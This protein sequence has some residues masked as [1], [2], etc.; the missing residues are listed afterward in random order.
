M[1]E[2]YRA[3]NGLEA[4]LVLSSIGWPGSH[5]AREECRSEDHQLCPEPVGRFVGSMNFFDFLTNDAHRDDIDALRQ[6]LED[7]GATHI[8]TYDELDDKKAIKAKI[9]EWTSG[10]VLIPSK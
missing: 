7:L 5:T 3:R 10:Q 8:V 2:P 1:L 9:K 4:Q 6:E